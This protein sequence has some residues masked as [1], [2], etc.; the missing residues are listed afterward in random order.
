MKEK[1]TDAQSKTES[2]QE[3]KPIEKTIRAKLAVLRENEK[4]GWNRIVTVT[5]WGEGGKFKLDIRDW[6]E[7]MNRS[8]KGMTFSREE[9]KK[10][11]SILSIIDLSIIDE[12]SGSA[13]PLADFTEEEAVAV[14]V[15]NDL[16]KR[17]GTGEEEDDD[18]VEMKSAV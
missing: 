16:L 9:V 1:M 11:R 13:I 17:G 18:D 10:L 3:F 8:T 5:R 6:D 14:P 15:N 4:T 7:K 2:R 12:Y